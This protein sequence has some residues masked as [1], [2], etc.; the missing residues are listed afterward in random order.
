MLCVATAWKINDFCCQCSVKYHTL[1]HLI[2]VLA[3]SCGHEV[4]LVHGQKEPGS[5]KLQPIL[6]SLMKPPSRYLHL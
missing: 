1:R 5:S 4:K 2:H 3:N 6:C